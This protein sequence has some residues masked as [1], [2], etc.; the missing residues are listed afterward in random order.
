[1]KKAMVLSLA[2]VLLLSLLVVTPA[3]ATTPEDAYGTFTWISDN[4]DGTTTFEMDGTFVGVATMHY[5]P[6][7]STRVV[8]DPCAVDGKSGTAVFNVVMMNYKQERGNWNSLYATGAL[9]GLHFQGRHERPI[10]EP[11]GIYYGKIHF[12]PK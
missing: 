4:P 2:V 7:W 8:C 1:M 6:G 12:D 11:E 3:L 10:D 9:E 5:L